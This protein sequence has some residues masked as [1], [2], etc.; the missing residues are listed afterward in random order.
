MEN[1]VN[2]CKNGKCSRCGNCCTPFIPMSKTEVKKI[3]TYLKRHPKIAEQA[4]KKP[5]IVNGDA[6]IQCCFYDVDK[7]ICTIY[8]VRPL[9]CQMFKCDQPLRKVMDNKDFVNARADYNTKVPKT[10]TDFRDLFFEDPSMVALGI[11][12]KLKNKEEFKKYCTFVGRED[13]LRF[14]K[15]D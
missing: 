1:T 12:G 10:I 9:I 15:E 13:L 5:I 4:F 7:K 11:F 6:I 2:F 8:D 14:I 3:R